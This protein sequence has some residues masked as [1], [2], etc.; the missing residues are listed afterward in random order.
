MISQMD[1]QTRRGKGASETCLPSHTALVFES[2]FL[3][4]APEIYTD[5][6]NQCLKCAAVSPYECPIDPALGTW[7]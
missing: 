2:I 1:P 4:L 3:D 6:F 5:H 7:V